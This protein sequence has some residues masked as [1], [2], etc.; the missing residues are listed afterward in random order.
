MSL[1]CCPLCDGALRREG[2]ALRCGA[3]HSF[4]IAREGYVNLLPVQAKH[5]LAPGGDKT[6]SAARRAFLDKGWYAPL[7]DA[8][9]ALAVELTSASPTVLDA[10]CGEGYYTS[11]IRQALEQA[12]KTPQVAGTDI[13]KF[14]LRSAARR[15]KEV[16]FAV[17]SS[18][19]LPLASES[20]ELLLDCFS[21]LA[22]EEFA[23]VL[24]PGGVFLYVIPAAEHLWEMKQVLYDRPY[25]NEEKETQYTGFTHERTV[26]VETEIDLPGE[27]L[28]ALFEMTP[29]AWKTPRVGRE[30][31]LGL[32][33]LQVRAVFRI[34]V[35]RRDGILED[36][37]KV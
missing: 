9:C 37:E 6:M 8:L 5:S 35:Y 7:R 32:D 26:P 15:D 24:R 18:Y 2:G 27:D 30:R 28:K 33:R 11:G 17:A 16:A 4:D 20:V 29:Y 13:S 14:I 10:G 25:R 23:R 1:F 22:A 34:L 12:G 21:P 31:L 3:G 36:G 19:H